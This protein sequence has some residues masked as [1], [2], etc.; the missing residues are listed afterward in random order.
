MTSRPMEEST[1]RVP[2]L[3]MA[4]CGIAVAAGVALIATAW[5]FGGAS[6]PPK[7]D[8]PALVKVAMRNLRFDPATVTISRGGSVEWINQDLVPHTATASTFDSGSLS[9]DQVWS[10]RFDQAGRFEYVCGFHP[11]MKGLVVVK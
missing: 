11:H 7:V 10:H 9:A 2:L 4:L 3:T 8:A 6:T 5:T 1:H